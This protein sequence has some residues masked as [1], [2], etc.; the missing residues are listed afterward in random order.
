MAH[1]LLDQARKEGRSLLEHEAKEFLQEKGLPVPPAGLARSAEEAVACA[2]KLGYP[3]VLKIV[4]PQI[5]HKT[6][7]GGVKINLS[8]SEEVRHAYD[9]IMAKAQEYDP[10]A[11][12]VGALVTPLAK[13]G[14]EVIIGMTKDPNFGPVVM[15]GLGG[16]FVEVFKDVTFRVAPLTLAD[17]KE[18]LEEIQGYELLQGVRGEKRRDLESLADLL[19]KVSELAVE[20]PE[21]R[22]V[23]LNPVFVY[24]KG[25]ALVDARIIL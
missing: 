15:F 20:E 21:I 2:D 8:N 4:S 14:T 16:V 19:L 24:E 17:A 9:E 5:I 11:R 7:A 23:D 10:E 12:I 18:M 22:E 1:R 25:L 3:V 6:D 13:A